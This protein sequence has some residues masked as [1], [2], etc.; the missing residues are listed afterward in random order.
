M[1]VNTAHHADKE[2]HYNNLPED[3]RA[4]LDLFPDLHLHIG[5]YYDVTLPDNISY[6]F[7]QSIDR[8]GNRDRFI[9]WV[10]A[11]MPEGYNDYDN[12]WKGEE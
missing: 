3:V 5:S 11:G 2:S 1:K 7:V 12:Q 4:I 9:S 6:V 8:P 10:R